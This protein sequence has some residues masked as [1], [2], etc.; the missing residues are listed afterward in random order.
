MNQRAADA[1]SKA[2]LQMVLKHPFFATIVCNMPWEEDNSIPT[3]ATDGKHVWYNADFVSALTTPQLLFVACHEV[4]HVIFGHAF[5]RGQRD[6]KKWNYAGDYVIN[7][8]LISEGIGEMP[9]GRFMGLHNPELVVAG[10]GTTDGVY[11]LLPDNYADADGGGQEGGTALDACKGMGTATEQASA[12]AETRVLVAKAAAVARMKGSMSA[13][14]ARMID[15]TLTPVVDWVDLLRRFAT[16][17][18]KVD[19]TYARPKRRFLMQGLYLPSLAG[20]GMGEFVVAVDCSGSIDE[21][22]L[23]E[24]AAEIVAISQDCQ[25]SRLHVVYFDSVVC[26]HDIFE[27][28]ETVTIAPHGGGGTAFS[29]VFRYLEE[30]NIQPC[31][32]V[33]LT[34]LYCSDFGP[35]PAHPVMWVTTAAT[36]APWGQVVEMQPKLKTRD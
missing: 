7:D 33:F 22:Q 6:I 25:P 36:A 23:S 21:R 9:T 4:G 3:M 17:A 34:D 24:F 27:R 19:R 28:G 30:H 11:H 18:A 14:L 16:E 20:V 5:R 8:L 31:A 32:T 15:H 10:G 2:K 29:P 12:E 13:G 35:A 1:V 26:H